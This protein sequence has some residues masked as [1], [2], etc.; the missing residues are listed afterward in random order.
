M[1]EKKFH[2]EYLLNDKEG[3]LKP[4]QRTAMQE[5]LLALDRALEEQDSLGQDDLVEFWEAEMA[6]GR[7]PDLSMKTKDIP[8]GWRKRQ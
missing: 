7:A 1:F 3:D 2:L 6:A 5:Q 8:A 4:E